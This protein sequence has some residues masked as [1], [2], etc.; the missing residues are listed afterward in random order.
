MRDKKKLRSEGP[1]NTPAALALAYTG[2]QEMKQGKEVKP[3]E[4]SIELTPEYTDVRQKEEG[5]KKKP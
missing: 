4:P 2:N 5:K 1:D 3:N